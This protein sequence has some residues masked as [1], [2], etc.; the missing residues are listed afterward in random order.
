[1]RYTFPVSLDYQLQLTTNMLVN[2]LHLIPFNLE[3]LI[4]KQGFYIKY[5]PKLQTQ[6]YPKFYLPSMFTISLSQSGHPTRKK[7]ALKTKWDKILRRH[8]LKK[9]NTSPQE[10]ARSFT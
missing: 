10:L 3:L 7:G 6:Q 5:P 8:Y 2:S 1:M 4:G 9:A